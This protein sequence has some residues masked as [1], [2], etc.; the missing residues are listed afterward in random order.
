MS[1]SR[2]VL[3]LALALALAA[4]AAS[5]ARAGG[6]GGGGGFGG[7]GFGGGAGSA[8]RPYGG[9]GGSSG[10]GTWI[11]IPVLA[12]GV[13]IVFAPDVA[14]RYARRRA[15][16]LEAAALQKM[17]AE[18]GAGPRE[19]AGLNDRIRECFFKVQDAWSNSDVRLSRPFVSDA[20]YARHRAQLAKM[21]RRLRMNRIKDLVLHDVRVVRLERGPDGKAAR[22]AARIEASARDWVADL[23]RGVVVDGDPDEHRRFVE[24]WSFSRHPVSGWVLD[25]IRRR[26]RLWA[27]KDSNL[28][29]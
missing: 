7:G 3:L 17:R 4:P 13:L 28:Q 2:T 1:R 29:P 9:S 12:A 11:L 18:Y 26:D 5:W 15:R 27:V 21:E 10:E 25:E 16:S 24:Y 19:L 6:G 8:S 22:C 23:R 20:L 14:G